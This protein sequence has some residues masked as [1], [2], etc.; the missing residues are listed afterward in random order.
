MSLCPSA[1]PQAS[2]LLA[3]VG[4]WPSLALGGTWGGGGLPPPGS[5][6][7]PVTGGVGLGESL[8]GQL[9]SMAGSA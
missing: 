7:E 1:V 9:C 3:Q 4:A 5:L 6:R 8:W 2:F